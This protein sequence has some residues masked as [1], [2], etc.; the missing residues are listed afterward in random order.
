ME[1]KMDKTKSYDTEVI[2]FGLLILTAFLYL[3]L[4]IIVDIILLTP[5]ILIYKISKSNIDRL[6][7]SAIT[8]FTYLL[9]WFYFTQT[10]E[11]PVFELKYYLLSS[12]EGLLTPHLSDG[13][14]RFILKS[15][16]KAFD[17]IPITSLVLP[18]FL[19]YRFKLWEKID[20]KD[21]IQN[22]TFS[23]N[24]FFKFKRASSDVLIGINK[25]NK[26]PVYLSQR[27]R[28]RHTQVIGA[29]GFGKSESVLMP[30]LENDIRNGNGLLLLDA[31][32][33]EQL[34]RC[35]HNVASRYGREKDIKIFTPGI[36]EISNTY[37]PFMWST[38]SQVM[39]KLIGALEWSEPYYK[40]MSEIAVLNVAK[41]LSACLKSSNIHAL[42]HGLKKPHTLLDNNFYHKDVKPEIQEFCA[43]HKK[44]KEALTGLIADL[45][46]ICDSVF[47]QLLQYQ[48]ESILLSADY[49][50]QKIIIFQLNTLEFSETSKII[51]K[52]ILQDIKQLCTYILR[53]TNPK[54]RPFFPIYL[55]DFA[56]FAM[57]EFAEFLSMTRASGLGITVL[58]Q[59]L[60]DLEAISPAF[61]KQIMSNTNNKI[62]LKV[63]DSDTIE[64]AARMTGTKERII[65][66]HQIG[67]GLFNATQRTGM[68][69]ESLGNEFNIHPR[70]FR[71]LK[72]GDA[73]VIVNSSN[74]LSAVQLNHI[75]MPDFDNVKLTDIFYRPNKPDETD[76][77]S[78]SVPAKTTPLKLSQELLS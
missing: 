60:G 56:S 38:P 21:L 73:V 65:T 57:P 53:N 37:S 11:S 72:I 61:K 48:E 5:F 52:I 70:V 62:I 8:L 10:M 68:G 6:L 20:V 59:S 4:G 69:S 54:T 14:L 49:Y 13:A 16:N 2:V 78:E 64:E 35:I 32:G 46:H 42:Y 15:Q 51:G 26:K 74:R 19:I 22:R 30:M 55:D 17:W 3:P 36:P 76:T 33:D 23:P 67:Q 44:N 31:K 28:V 29:T 47:G 18:A 66:T 39:N 27:E 71:K 58:H 43:Q 25:E 75:A 41:A 7:F 34:L 24:Q 9:I 1:T 50:D 40:K 12:L 45:G 77:N 63:N